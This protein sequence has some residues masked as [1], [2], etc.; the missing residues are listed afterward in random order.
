MSVPSAPRARS[1]VLAA[2]LLP[3]VRRRASP[4]SGPPPTQCGAL[5]SRRPANRMVPASAGRGA[6]AP[7]RRHRPAPWH[8][9]SG[10]AVVLPP[11]GR[12]I[13]GMPKTVAGRRTVS[14]PPNVLPAAVEHLA[15]FVGPE[16]DAWLISANG[17]SPISP[18]TL[19]LA[20]RQARL[21]IGR[22]DLHLHDLR[23]SGLTWAAATGAS[24]RE[25]MALGGHAS[26]RCSPLPA[27]HRRPRPGPGQRTRRARPSGD[28][29]ADPTLC[30]VATS[31]LKAPIPL[32]RVPS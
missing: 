4:K 3:S 10:A 31:F 2:Q 22:P 5:Q 28:C 24:T 19:E 8:I 1:R 30:R 21:A 18:S 9:E 13:V 14:V 11:G 25:L 12:P 20:W 16:P 26:P 6:R 27:R 15:S 7:T 23:H 29:D 17:G 32:R